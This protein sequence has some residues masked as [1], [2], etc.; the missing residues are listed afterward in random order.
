MKK[1]NIKIGGMHCTSCVMLIEGDLEDCAGV[2]NATC[3]Y[4][5]GECMVDADDT[6]DKNEI[7]KAIISDG[8]T[9]EAMEEV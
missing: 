4:A 1:Y 8:Y 9:V 7:K 6:I 3:N 2:K 5:K